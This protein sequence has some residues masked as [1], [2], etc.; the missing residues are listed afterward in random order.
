[1][2]V[3]ILGAFDAVWIQGALHPWMVED[4]WDC[5]ALVRD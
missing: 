1:M 2:I 4:L 3:V 5:D